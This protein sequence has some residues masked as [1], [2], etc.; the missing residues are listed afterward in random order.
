MPDENKF[1]KLG[2]LQYTIQHVC[3]LCKNGR[4]KPMTEW[5]TCRVHTYEHKKHDN[6]EG[7]RGVSIHLFGSCSEFVA[8][9]RGLVALGA[10]I[11]FFSP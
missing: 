11:K 6:P 3:G 9:Q 1:K 4:F 7:G 2:E 8:E 5:G 10:H